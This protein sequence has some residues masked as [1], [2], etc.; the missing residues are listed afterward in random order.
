MVGVGGH[1]SPVA[2]HTFFPNC[3]LIDT[4]LGNGDGSEDQ[5]PLTAKDLICFAFQIAQGMEYLSSMKVCGL[6]R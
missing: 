5:V 6:F 3:Y 2:I 1:L 4:N